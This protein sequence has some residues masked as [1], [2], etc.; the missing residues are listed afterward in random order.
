MEWRLLDENEAR[1]AWNPALARFPDCN[2]YQSFEWGEYRRR[3]AGVACHRWAAFDAQQQIVALF[4]GTLVR[5]LLGRGVVTGL[6]GPVG[7]LRVA[8]PSLP[9]A[10]RGSLGLQG[11]YLWASLARR[12]GAE[13]ALALRCAGWQRA[14]HAT[15]SGLTMWLDLAPDEEEIL[16]GASQKWR[17]TLRRALKQ[18]L[19]VERW[20]DPDPAAVVT[21]YQEMAGLKGVAVDFTAA[22]VRAIADAFGDNLLLFRCNDADGALLSLRG[23]LVTH[24]HGLD[25]FAATTARGRETYASYAVFWAVLQACRARGVLRYDL[26]HIDPI[27]GPGVYQFKRGVGAAP[28]E[29]LGDWE[30]ASSEPLRIAM[31]LA[32]AA[33]HRWR[34]RRADAAQVA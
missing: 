30:W 4:Q 12:Y 24:H 18:E 13:D 17:Q 25:F 19:R 31:N 29:Y 21:A 20:L 2:A 10:V 23:C 22:E 14:L 5:R 3:A 1:A 34:T 6:G 11:V 15:S 16:K 32:K 8:A 7:D 9:D 28:I 33:Q 27:R 26:N